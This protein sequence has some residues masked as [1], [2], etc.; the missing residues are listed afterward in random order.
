MFGNFKNMGQQLKMAQMLMKDERFRAF[1]MNPK[2]Q[3][4]MRDPEFQA[5]AKTQNMDKIKSHPKFS[6]L[7]KDPQMVQM[8]QQLAGT[9]Q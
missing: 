1:I 8:M 3:E 5:I 6:A 2:V 4:L 7:M 9:M